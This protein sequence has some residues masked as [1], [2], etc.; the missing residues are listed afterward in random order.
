MDYS[1]MPFEG[2]LA[3]RASPQLIAPIKTVLTGKCTQRK[4]NRNFFKLLRAGLTVS[5]TFNVK[6]QLEDL[7][8]NGL[9][10]KSELAPV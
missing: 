1:L 10:V 3:P 2:S 8:K 4:C 9:E 6:G 5:N 7:A